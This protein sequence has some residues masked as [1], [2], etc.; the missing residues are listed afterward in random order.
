MATDYLTEEKDGDIVEMTAGEAIGKGN[1]VCVLTTDGECYVAA[2]TANYLF[3]GIALES[4]SGNAIEFKVR[5]DEHLV[6]LTYTPGS[7]AQAMVGDVVCCDGA[8]SCAPPTGSGETTN[9]IFL[10]HIVDIISTTEVWVRVK[11]F[12]VNPPAAA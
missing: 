2:D 7:A 1:L 9:D 8:N 3:A 12:P 5:Q 11:P 4:A 10:G 6:R